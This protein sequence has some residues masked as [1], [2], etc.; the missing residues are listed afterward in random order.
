[1]KKYF[2]PHLE[3]IRIPMTDITTDDIIRTSG[4]EAEIIGDGARTMP[5]SWESK[6]LPKS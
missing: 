2:C 1:M 4:Q 5:S 6:L 3:M